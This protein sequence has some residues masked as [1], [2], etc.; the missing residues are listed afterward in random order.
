MQHF[1][2]SAHL[3]Y[4]L[5]PTIYPCNHSPW[6]I[7][8]WSM[9]DLFH[10][11]LTHIQWVFRPISPLTSASRRDGFSMQIHSLVIYFLCYTVSF[12]IIPRPSQTPYFKFMVH[13]IFSSIVQKLPVPLRILWYYIWF[14][15]VLE[16][17][18]LLIYSSA[19]WIIVSA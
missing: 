6:H 14:K 8:A 5:K 17:E 7:H 2:I 15:R 1:G 4:L 13:T 11:Y 16:A 12:S 18:A 3:N 10:F 19:V 9:F